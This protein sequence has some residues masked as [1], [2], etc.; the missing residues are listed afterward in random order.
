MIVIRGG[1]KMPLPN[2]LRSVLMLMDITSI[3]VGHGNTGEH[4]ESRR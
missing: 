1:L 3:S 4:N 2:I